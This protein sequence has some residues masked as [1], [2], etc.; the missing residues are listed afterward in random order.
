MSDEEGKVPDF[1]K[2]SLYKWTGGMVDAEDVLAGVSLPLL[3]YLSGK[4]FRFRYALQG[5]MNQMS[6][7]QI[8]K[9]TVTDK[10]DPANAQ[11]ISAIVIGAL[12]SLESV[13]WT[14]KLPALET[15]IKESSIGSLA[16]VLA[17]SVGKTWVS[18]KLPAYTR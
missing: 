11:A 16:S 5:F 15:V 14:W 17:A 9:M 10:T 1:F 18:P 3:Q 7:R 13:L 8:M 4:S 2:S 12:T 6:V